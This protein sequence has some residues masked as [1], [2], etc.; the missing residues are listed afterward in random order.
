MSGKI[1]AGGIVA[2]ALIAGIAMYYLQVYYYYEEVDVANE[3][4]VLT[5]FDGTEEPILADAIEAIDAT[6]SPIRYRACF[7]TPL[8]QAQLT[9][10]YQIYEAAEPLVA[11]FWFDCFDAVEIGHALEDGRALAFLG[12]KNIHHGVDRVVAIDAD[13]RGFVWN[14]VNE[15]IRK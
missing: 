10:T 13:G 2:L 1:M 8:S 14:Q 11:P 4:I 12:R 9:E 3:Q 6:S 15:E 7:T 5:S